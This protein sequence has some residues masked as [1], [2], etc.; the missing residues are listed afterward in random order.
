MRAHKWRHLVLALLPHP[1][2]LGIV[3]ASAPLIDRQFG[4]CT[5][6]S[7]V[8]PAAGFGLDPRRVVQAAAHPDSRA[9]AYTECR[10]ESPSKL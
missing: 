4:L 6:A 9:T 7:A 5:Q 2:V 3:A 8:L 10:V 1:H